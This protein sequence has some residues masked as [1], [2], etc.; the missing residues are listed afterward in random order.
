MNQVLL[1]ECSI[2]SFITLR[3]GLERDPLSGLVETWAR[4]WHLSLR[5]KTLV[6]S[7]TD[8]RSA[9]LQFDV[10]LGLDFRGC[11]SLYGT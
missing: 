5:G 3:K 10:L 11:L 2:D 6:Q 1:P 9:L 7:R 4:H 8:G